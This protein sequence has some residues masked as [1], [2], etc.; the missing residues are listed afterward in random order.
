LGLVE[1]VED[2]MTGAIQAAKA[3]LKEPSAR[4]LTV[5]RGEAHEDSDELAFSE[6]ERS[7]LV[8]PVRLDSHRLQRQAEG[9]H[10]SASAGRFWCR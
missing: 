10:H 9:V 7:L 1:V 6:Y 4:E 3:M 5:L 8:R 2:R